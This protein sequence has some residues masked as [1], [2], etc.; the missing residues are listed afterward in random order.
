MLVPKSVFAVRKIADRDSSRYAL[1]GIRFE[2]DE[3]TGAPLA[4][5][6]DG[7]RLVAVTW[8][9]D[10][11]DEYP[12][13]PGL[14]AGKREGAQPFILPYAACDAASKIKIKTPKPILENIVLQEPLADENTV[15]IFATDCDNQHNTT[16]RQLDG[17][18][19]RWRDVFPAYGPDDISIKFDARYLRDLLEALEATA[20]SDESRAVVLTISRD[21]NGHE[22]PILLTAVSANV[23]AAAVLMPLSVDRDGTKPQPA[24]QFLPPLPQAAEDPPAADEDAADEIE[25]P[26]DTE[27]AAEVDTELEPAAEPAPEIVAAEIVAEVAAEIVEAVAVEPTAD[28]L[29]PEPPPYIDPPAREVS[30]DD[31]RSRARRIACAAYV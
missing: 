8:N 9:E 11:A 5:A 12:A 26:T 20:G 28:H 16:A 21:D 13:A 14:V 7:R 15:K 6:C 17:R 1:G 2:R 31:W 19:P 29:E 27:P 25:E 18:F 22:K 10:N 30:R 3:K 23:A 24:R 4:V